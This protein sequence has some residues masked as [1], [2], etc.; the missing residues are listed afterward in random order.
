MPWVE[1]ELPNEAD[2][3]LSVALELLWA[4]P[5]GNYRLLMSTM[6]EVAG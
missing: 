6:I 1:W 3:R 5:R 2:S 4:S